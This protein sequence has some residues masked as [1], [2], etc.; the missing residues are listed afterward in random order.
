MAKTAAKKAP[1]KRTAATEA[2]DTGVEKTAAPKAK[3]GAVNK[4]D[5]PPPSH[6]QIGR[7][8]YQ[9]WEEAG[10][11][12]GQSEAFWSRAERELRGLGPQPPR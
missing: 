2:K 5:M 1:A 9:L 12:H 7:V 10:R 4:P 8:A 11:P 6:E 3:R